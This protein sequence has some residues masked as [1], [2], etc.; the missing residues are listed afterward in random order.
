M[1]HCKE[2]MSPA[3]SLALFTVLAVA[4]TANA[5]GS[6]DP[7][8]TADLVTMAKLDFALMPAVVQ[9]DGGPDASAP[10]APR[11]LPQRFGAAGSQRLYYQGA[12]GFRLNDT[13]TIFGHVGI[14]FSHFI[15]DGLS[16]NVEVN[17]GYFDSSDSKDA[18]TGNANLLFRWHFYQETNWSIYFDGGAGVMGSTQEVPRNG[19]NFN[20]TPQAGVGVSFDIAAD[21]RMLIGARWHHVSNASLYDDNPGMDNFLGY[22]AISVPF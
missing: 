5:G 7:S 11:P 10:L 17:F 18:W 6:G 14:G 4:G 12:G 21:T 9:D 13:E 8:P 20:F 2:A 1:C 3:C 15:A 22:L 19:T 16:L